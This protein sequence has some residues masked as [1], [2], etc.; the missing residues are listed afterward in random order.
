ME[1]YGKGVVVEEEGC[2]ILILADDIGVI[3]CLN[4]GTILNV[5]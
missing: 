3:F 2:K 4:P 5:D 1:E